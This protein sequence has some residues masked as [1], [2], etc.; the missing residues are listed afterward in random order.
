[1]LVVLV[2]LATA[3]VHIA[4]ISGQRKLDRLDVEISAARRVQ[5]SL[6]RSE[7]EL[8]SPAEVQRIAT[9]QLGMVPA[10]PPQLVSPRPVLIGV[11]PIAAPPGGEGK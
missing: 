5:E 1:V 6:R 8:K 10:A 7:T 4:L 2:M 3:A 9:E 11:L